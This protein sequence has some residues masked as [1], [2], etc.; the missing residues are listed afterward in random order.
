MNAPDTPPTRAATIVAI[1]VVVAAAIVVALSIAVNLRAGAGGPADAAAIAPAGARST[2][3]PG[4]TSCGDPTVTVSTAKQLKKALKAAGPGTSI[5]LK[6][7]EYSGRFIATAQGTEDEPIVLCG[8]RDAVLD[9]GGIKKGY[10]LHLDGVA[11]WTVSGFSVR[12]GQK[13]VMADGTTFSTIRDLHVSGIGDEAIHLRNFSTDNTVEG[14]TIRDTGLRKPKFG[15][16]IYVGTAESNWEDVTGGKPD[17]SDRN[18][19]VGN[20]IAGTTSESVDLKEGTSGGVLRDNT[21]DGSEITGADSWVDVKGN[22][23]LIEGN[24]GTNAPL[25]GFQTHEIVDGWGTDNVFRDN[26][27]EVNGDGFGYSITPKLDNV[28]ECSNEASG[29]AEGLSNMKCSR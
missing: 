24:A 22:D 3:E 7:G 28:V 2:S 14:N 4:G 16:G 11:H 5:R 19:V 13:G 20:D 9:G 6:P 17:A 29:A 21:F 25:D 1:A 18:T 15:E 10:V 12:N 23:W 27:A 26:Q 8:P